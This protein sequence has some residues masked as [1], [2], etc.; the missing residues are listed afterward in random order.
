MELTKYLVYLKGEDVPM[1]IDA[2][3]KEVLE[4]ELTQLGYNVS[5][6]QLNY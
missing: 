5:S 3:S 6:I 1:I 4:Q 2:V